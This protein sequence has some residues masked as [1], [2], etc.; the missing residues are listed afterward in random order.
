VNTRWTTGLVR[1]V[2]APD[3]AKVRGLLS[4]Q[5]ASLAVP[6]SVF[7]ATEFVC[8]VT[9]EAPE[10][11]LH[12]YLESVDQHGKVRL[13]TEG[14]QRIRSGLIRMDLRS[15][16]FEI[17]AGWSLRLSVAGADAPS[18]ERVP[19]SGPQRMQF[20][21]SGCHIVLPTVDLVTK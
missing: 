21:G 1:P 7:G 20:A 8:E 5:A 2:D 16:A 18:F 17:P 15:V 14:I 4:W 6:L 19:A 13:L 10:A 3:R 12:V 9:L 11:A